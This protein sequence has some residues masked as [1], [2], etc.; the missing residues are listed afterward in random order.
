[1]SAIEAVV[2]DLDGTLIDSVP[3][4]A[5]AVN[6]LLVEDG[7][8]TFAIEELKPMIGR[9]AGAM[10]EK[11][12]LLTGA[13]LEE[14]GVPAAVAR[15]LEHYLRHPAEGT[16]VFPGGREILARFAADGLPLGICTN[17]PRAAT[18][19]VLKALGLEAFFRGVSC[20]DAPARK[21]DGRHVRHTLEL[22]GAADRKAALVGD[23]EIDMAA[24]RD[25]GVAAIA[26]SWG[27]PN[28]ASKPLDADVTIDRFSDLPAALETVARP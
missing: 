10:L 8:R 20:D 7:R 19:S 11:A 27:Y 18:A 22:M 23:S 21:P 5:A 17:K 3:D 2:F 4:V 15:Y 24:A 25:A 6:R 14:S 26:V 16:V 1:M 12:F 9:G 13:P 28:N